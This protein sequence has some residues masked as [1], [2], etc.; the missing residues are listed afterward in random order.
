[1][2]SPATVEIWTMDKCILAPGTAA[3]ELNRLIARETELLE[4]NNG[5][6]ERARSAEG[7]LKS[8]KAAA[9]RAIESDALHRNELWRARNEIAR[10]NERGSFTFLEMEA[11]L[12][13]WEWMLDAG[14]KTVERWRDTIGTKEA[15]HSSYSIGR[16]CLKIFDLGKEIGGPLAW[17]GGAYDWEVIPAICETILFAENGE[18]HFNDDSVEAAKFALHKAN[19]HKVERDRRGEE[20][21]PVISVELSA[22]ARMAA[23]VKQ[24][25]VDLKAFLEP[26][27]IAPLSFR[28]RNYRGEVSVRTV[29]PLNIYFGSTEWHPEPQWL[30]AAT[31]IEKGERRD[32]AIKDINPPAFTNFEIDRLIAAVEGE[33]DGLAI[34]AKQAA[35][36]LNYLIFEHP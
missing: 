22:F 5:Y 7:F 11:A 28:Y 21:A 14:A 31:D 8:W 1:M 35:A 3:R 9:M 34:D 15:R 13:V 33:C 29:R 2:P 32:F 20:V 26:L 19:N 18:Y 27:D 36:I 10:A 30:L 4:A 24:F 6:L 16:Y 17:D 25:G 23:A 12:C